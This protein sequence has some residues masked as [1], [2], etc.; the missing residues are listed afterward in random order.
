MFCSLK[1]AKGATCLEA[2]LQIAEDSGEVTEQR[3]PLC[4]MSALAV[5][6]HLHGVPC[7]QSHLF[8]PPRELDTPPPPHHTYTCIPL[9]VNA[10]K[11]M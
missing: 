1:S 5:R 3:R 10:A 7:H 8:K 6:C 11:I 9:S 4:I 2:D